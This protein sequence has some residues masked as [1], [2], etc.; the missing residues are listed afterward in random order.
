[1]KRMLAGAVLGIVSVTVAQADPCSGKAAAGIVAYDRTEREALALVLNQCGRPV[2]VEMLVI[3]S[4]HDGF[5][6]AKMPVNVVVAKSTPLSVVT[7]DLP[8]VQSAVTEVGYVAEVRNV[9][10]M[11]YPPEFAAV[12]TKTAEHMVK[13]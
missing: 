4:N 2:R 13:Q 3:A 1:M 11:G 9:V 10:A 6:V 8:F 7:I 12:T 5:A